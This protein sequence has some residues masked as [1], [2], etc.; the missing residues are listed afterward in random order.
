MEKLVAGMA[1]EEKGLTHF[2]GQGP[3]LKVKGQRSNTIFKKKVSNL[4]F[5]I[6]K[7]LPKQH[8]KI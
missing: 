6:Q 4:N 8:G 1:Y 5:E 3:S 7:T 2:Q